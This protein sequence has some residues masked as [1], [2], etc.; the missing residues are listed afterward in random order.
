VIEWEPAFRA[1]PE[2]AEK[3]LSETAQY[4]RETNGSLLTLKAF[5]RRWIRNSLRNF[6][7]LDYG[8]RLEKV[9]GPIL[10]AASGVSLRSVMPE[11]R[12]FR[13]RFSLWALPSAMDYLVHHK[14]FPDLIVL[15]DP[16]YYSSFHLHNCLRELRPSGMAVPLLLP[17]T[18]AFPT[19]PGGFS[20]SFFNQGTWYENI[21]LQNFS[22]PPDLVPQNGTVAGTALEIALTKTEGPV[23][24]AGL[25][26]ACRDIF[27]HVRPHA[28]DRIVGEICSRLIPEESFRFEKLIL[29]NPFNLGRGLRTSQALRTY[30]GWFQRQK[31][32]WRDRVVRLNATPV[33]TGMQSAGAGV[34]EG[35]SGGKPECFF[36]PVKG[37]GRNEKEEILRRFI[38][39]YDLSS[40]IL[41]LYRE[42]P[43]ESDNP[44]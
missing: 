29:R 34:L 1:Y 36:T 23:F 25:D 33:D 10:I 12:R 5:G 16:G 21:L 19:G 17:L 31:N 42:R 39:H 26:L 38:S 37:P 2:R 7:H 14:V 40:M 28:L 24:I 44:G 9:S 35:L 3:I 20:F 41:P 11:I 8:R 6:L 43:H 13:G 27:E 22:P 18:A 4:C 30:A 32:R 15:T